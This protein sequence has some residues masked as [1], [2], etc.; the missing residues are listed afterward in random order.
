MYIIGLGDLAGGLLASA[1]LSALIIG[2]AL[3]DIGENFL[4]G[5]ILA[6]NRPFDAG[7]VVQTGEFSGRVVALD[8]RSLQ[9]KSFDGK[10]IYIPNATVLKNPFL[11]YTQ[12]GLIRYDFVVGIDY[13]DDVERARDVIVE[14]IRAIEGVLPEDPPFIVVDELAANSVNLRVFFSV[15]TYDYK[16]AATILRGQVIER[17]KEVLLVNGFTLPATIVEHKLYDER[18]PLKVSLH[19]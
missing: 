5:I 19:G 13:H 12:D 16:R 8:L 15:D 11:N 14:A 9:I 2:F 6:V 1:G 17:T 10:D 4:A 3:R 7:D 18:Q